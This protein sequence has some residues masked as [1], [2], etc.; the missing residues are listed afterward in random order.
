MARRD[1]AWPGFRQTGPIC[2]RAARDQRDLTQLAKAASRQPTRHGGICPLSRF[3][4]AGR[5]G[6][7]TP[8]RLLRRPLGG[9]VR[10]PP[11]STASRPILATS[12]EDAPRWAGRNDAGIDVCTKQ[13]H[14]LL[15]EITAS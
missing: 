13:E 9:G 6:T 1:D 8:H 7:Y 4:V 2:L 11:A 3:S 15:V 5:C 12:R 10:L 14:N